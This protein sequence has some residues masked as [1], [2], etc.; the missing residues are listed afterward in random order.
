MLKEARQ[1]AQNAAYQEITGPSYKRLDQAMA[2]IEGV[3]RG[4]AEGGE[5]N[6]PIPRRDGVAG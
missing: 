1:G 3:R 6:N 2:R 4:D 5:S